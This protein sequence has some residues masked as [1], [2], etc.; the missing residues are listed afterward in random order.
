ML[1]A[2][3]PY[4]ELRM[5]RTQPR[6]EIRKQ[7]KKRNE[8]NINLINWWNMKVKQIYRPNSIF[9]LIK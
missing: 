5:A 3:R 8:T 1:F 6:T 9:L 7:K 2:L 4:I